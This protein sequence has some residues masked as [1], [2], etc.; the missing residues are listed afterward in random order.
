M[1]FPLSTRNPVD[2]QFM[3]ALLTGWAMVDNAEREKAHE[4]IRDHDR[5]ITP[6]ML[7]RLANS[8]E[9]LDYGGEESCLLCFSFCLSTPTMEV[10]NSCLLCCPF[11]LSP[12]SHEG[13]HSC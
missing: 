3:S 10:G 8:I 13:T 7:R 4:W 1:T 5:T 9:N 12:L 11:C 2:I 6:A